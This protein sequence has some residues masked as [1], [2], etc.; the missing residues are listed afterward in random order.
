[1]NAKSFY[2]FDDP[3]RIGHIGIYLPAGATR[4]FLLKTYADR[5]GSGASVRTRTD[6]MA[7]QGD[8]EGELLS[9]WKDHHQI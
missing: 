2:E 7:C 3:A 5:V 1:M 4:K 8:V 6:R 9:V